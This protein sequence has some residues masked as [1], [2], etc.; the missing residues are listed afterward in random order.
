MT[1]IQ[2]ILSALIAAAPLALGAASPASA[3]KTETKA[4]RACVAS[5]ANL[6]GFVACTASVLTAVEATKCFNSGFK[7]C[8]G[9]H[10]DLTRFVRNNIAGP[11]NDIATGHLGGS[12]AS[13]WRQMGLPEMK[14]F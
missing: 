8:F 14:L 10:N 7:D 11:L 9:E 5:A 6:P 1:T 13:V 3:G 4:V 12:D 2:K